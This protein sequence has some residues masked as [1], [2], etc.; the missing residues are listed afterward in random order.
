MDIP[1]ETALLEGDALS[2][3]SI[4]VQPKLLFPS[5]NSI[6]SYL[7]V[8]PKFNM[9]YTNDIMIFATDDDIVLERKDEKLLSVESGIGIDIEI[10]R[11][12]LFMEV[13]ID[14][15]FRSSENSILMPI[16]FGVIIPF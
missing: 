11:T 1:S 12:K 5:T 7:F 15:S 2:I 4:A 14:Y 6:V 9:L 16:R 10:E 8:S 3:P 13:G